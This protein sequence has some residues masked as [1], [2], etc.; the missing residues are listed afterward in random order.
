MKNK[1]KLITVFAAGL[2]LAACGVLKNLDLVGKQSAASFAEVLKTIPD[3]VRADE[4]NTGWE[5]YAPDNSARFFW[6]ADYSKSPIYDVMLE[7]DAR[8]FLDAGLDIGK[9]PD[10]YSV[11]VH[12]T[13]GALGNVTLIV[14]KKFGG[15][16]HEHDHDG[17]ATPLA[18]YEQIAARRKESINYHT[19]LDH[20]G[21]DMGNGNLFEWAKDLQTNGYDNSDQDKDIVFVLNPEPL[22]QAGAEPERVAGWAYAQVDVDDENGKPVKVWKFLKPFDIA[23]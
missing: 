6:S 5:L 19:A 21:V 23:Q 22:I 14:G 17:G 9:L 18:A 11:S 4:Q 15:G 1:T 3:K 10:A 7:F 8:P 13:A 2:A 12:E 20:F 16:E